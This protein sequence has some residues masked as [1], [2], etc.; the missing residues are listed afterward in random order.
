MNDQPLTPREVADTLRIVNSTV[1]ELVKRGELRA[2]R[3]GNKFRFNVQ[4]VE[5]Y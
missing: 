5:A 4:D 3:V 2:Y 1:Y